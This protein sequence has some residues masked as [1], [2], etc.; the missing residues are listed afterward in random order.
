MS[1]IEW[2]PIH[3]VPVINGKGE[4]TT[5]CFRICSLC[6]GKFD[7]DERAMAQ[8]VKDHETGQ[9]EK[10][11]AALWKRMQ[12]INALQPLQGLRPGEKAH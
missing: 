7:P 11:E 1:N 12:E 5:I 4:R 8:H 9:V 3:T 2:S 10:E 6:G